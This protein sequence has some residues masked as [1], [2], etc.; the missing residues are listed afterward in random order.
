MVS[1]RACKT[2]GTRQPMKSDPMSAC[3]LLHIIQ[4]WAIRSKLGD[5]LLG[6]TIAHLVARV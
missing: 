5:G 3:R 1:S 4:D 2:N 6:W